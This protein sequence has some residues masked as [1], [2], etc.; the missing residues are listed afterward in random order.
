MLL[1]LVKDP[2]VHSL[3]LSILVIG[4]LL[5]SHML[6]VPVVCVVEAWYTSALDIEESL[7]G[8]VDSEVHIFAAHVVESFVLDCVLGSLGLPPWFQHVISSNLA[9]VRLRFKH[10]YCCALFSIV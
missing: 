3:L 6:S 1:L 4:L 10:F 2:G 9:Y 5:G 8:I 7:S